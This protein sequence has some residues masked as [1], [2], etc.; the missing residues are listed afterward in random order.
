MAWT[1]TQL[2]SFGFGDLTEEKFESEASWAEVSLDIPDCLGGGRLLTVSK[3]FKKENF[4][5]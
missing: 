4:S 2:K 3:T 1:L 5:N